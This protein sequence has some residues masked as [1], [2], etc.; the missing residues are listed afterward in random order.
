MGLRLTFALGVA[1]LGIT[2]LAPTAS[3]KELAPGVRCEVHAC[4]NDT[5]DVYRVD[6]E[7]T[8]WNGISTQTR[9]IGRRTTELMNF[10]CTAKMDHGSWEHQPPEIRDGKHVHVP[11]KWVPG[12]LIP[13]EPKWVEYVNAVVD[14]DP[15]PARS[16]SAG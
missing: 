9:Y 15:P 1:A 14:N 4:R 8:C 16:G 3:A 2:A 10:T 11:P 5:D 12:K 7:V 6:A 13:Q